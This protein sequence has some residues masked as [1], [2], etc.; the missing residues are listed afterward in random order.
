MDD[1]IKVHHE[2]LPDKNCN[3]FSIFGNLGGSTVQRQRLRS[4]SNSLLREYNPLR[5]N[6]KSLF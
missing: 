3:Y 4:S 5:A 2:C 1:E 6:I